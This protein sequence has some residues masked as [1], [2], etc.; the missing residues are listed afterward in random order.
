MFVRLSVPVTIK[1]TSNKPDNKLQ[2]HL[3]TRYEI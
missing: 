2:I 3:F 1:A